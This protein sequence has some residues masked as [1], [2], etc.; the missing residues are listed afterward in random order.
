ML[1]LNTKKRNLAKNLCINCF[2]AAVINIR[3]LHSPF[4]KQKLFAVEFMEGLT[5]FEIGN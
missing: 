2:S 4:R 5:R 3:K 1:P